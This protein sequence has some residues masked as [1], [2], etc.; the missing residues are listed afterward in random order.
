MCIVSGVVVWGKGLRERCGVSV[1]V[2]HLCIP[3]VLR[4]VVR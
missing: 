4:G 1:G 3:G 2:A